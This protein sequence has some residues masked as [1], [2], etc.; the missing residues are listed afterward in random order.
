[1]LARTALNC[2]HGMLLADVSKLQTLSNCCKLQALHISYVCWVT[3]V[4]PAIIDRV[5]CVHA[6]LDDNGRFC[7]AC[8]MELSH[9]GLW[10]WSQLVTNLK[11]QP[12]RQSMALASQP[13]L[14]ATTSFKRSSL[15]QNE[16]CSWQASWRCIICFQV[17]SSACTQYRCKNALTYEL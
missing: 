4:V 13:Y 5:C 10:I 9:D 6:G 11:A 8:C 16:A 1:M 2:L 7:S 17:Y 14:F 12:I 15:Q 3:A